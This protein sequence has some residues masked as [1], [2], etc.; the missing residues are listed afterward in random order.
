MD[1]DPRSA[2]R[3]GDR[4]NKAVLLLAVSPEGNPHGWGGFGARMMNPRVCA[5]PVENH[6]MFRIGN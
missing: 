6:K 2:G 1:T 4:G 5:W 3:G